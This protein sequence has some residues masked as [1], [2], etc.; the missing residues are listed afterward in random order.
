MH[1]M[2]VL[3][4]LLPLPHWGDAHQG[5]NVPVCTRAASV[6]PSLTCS[7]VHYTRCSGDYG[8]GW[9]AA[10]VLACLGGGLAAGLV[11]QAKPSSITREN[12]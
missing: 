8:R 1:G 3:E 11:V 7:A 4:L 2:N 6:W 10:A 12:L 5:E 9:L